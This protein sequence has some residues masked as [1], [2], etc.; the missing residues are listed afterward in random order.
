[1]DISKG[2][3]GDWKVSSIYKDYV[4]M[5]TNSGTFS[6]V[7]DIDATLSFDGAG[8]STF[9]MG[10]Q[11]RKFDWKAKDDTTV[12]LALD[13]TSNSGATVDSLDATYDPEL[14]AISMDL[15]TDGMSGNATF[16]RDSTLGKQPF[17][18]QSEAEVVTSIDQI[19]GTWELYGVVTG[20]ALMLGDASVLAE[21]GPSTDEKIVIESNGK[22]TLGADTFMIY[23]E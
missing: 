6:G 22:I 7:A 21:I 5:A 1:M 9:G 15:V 13:K 8:T 2:I 18:D 4:T 11:S 17:F 20:D 16:S 14:N 23:R 3:I 10:E 12:T 19:V